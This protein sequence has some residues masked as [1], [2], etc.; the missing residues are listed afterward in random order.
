MRVR[1]PAREEAKPS[2]PKS[3]PGPVPTLGDLALQTSWVWLYCEALGCRHKAPLKLAARI[4]RYGEG[5]TSSVL[6]ERTRCTH[7]GTLGATLRLPSWIGAGI[8]MARFP[9]L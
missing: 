6:R 3:P 7:C 9:A 4:G 1:E 8:G 5:M 2:R